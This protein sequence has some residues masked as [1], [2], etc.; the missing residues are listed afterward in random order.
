MKRL[1]T[2]APAVLLFA[3]GCL[4]SKGDIE[5]L[6]TELRAT[7]AQ[8]AMGDSSI[9]RADGNRQAQI[10]QVSAKLD[11]ALDSLRVLTNRV[12]AFQATATGNFDEMNQQL[13][14]MQALVGQ[15]TRNVQEARAQLQALRESGASNMASPPPA[16]SAPATTTDTSRGASSVAPAPGIPGPATLYESASNSINQGAYS[17]GRRALEQLLASYPTSEQAPRAMLRIGETY[18]VEGNQAASD[19]VYRLVADRYPKNSEAG[20]ALYRIGKELW[21]NGKKSEARTYLNRVIRDFPNSDA[22]RLAKDTLN[23]RE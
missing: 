13:L 8:L 18:K 20:L 6:Q 9:L 4:A 1:L 14:Q 2:I 5:Q 12:A 16:S 10:A 21:D 7:R 3:A 23:P 19:S 15:N 17:T 11:R 22:A